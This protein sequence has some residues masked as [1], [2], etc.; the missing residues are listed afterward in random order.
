[1][2]TLTK[3]SRSWNMSRIRGRDT[4]PECAVRSILH[5]EGFRFRLHDKSLPGTPDVVLPKYRCAIFV[6]GC[7]W[8]RHKRC[9]LAYTP[10]SRTRFW[11]RK[12]ADNVA[13]DKRVVAALRK[14]GWRV[15]VIW[16]CELITP[17]EIVRRVRSV[18]DTID[19]SPDSRVRTSPGRRGP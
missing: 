8:H 3:A 10:R 17:V 16:E 6:H 15:V 7:F 9:S 12:F 5:K 14:L 11:N 4:Q 2:D 19:S 18:V 1:M 13:R